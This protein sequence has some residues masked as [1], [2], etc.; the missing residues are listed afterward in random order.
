MLCCKD[1][2][3]F[4]PLTFFRGTDIVVYVILAFVRYNAADSA[5]FFTLGVQELRQVPGKE[6]V[7]SRLPSHITVILTPALSSLGLF[8]PAEWSQSS[9]I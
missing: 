2:F 3:G 5:V 9:S 1:D 6:Q 8:F 4:V 7:S